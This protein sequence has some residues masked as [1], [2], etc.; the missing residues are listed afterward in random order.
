MAITPL[1]AVYDLEVSARG[2]DQTLL[3]TWINTLVISVIY[4][5]KVTN[6]SNTKLRYTIVYS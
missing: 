5:W 2:T 6:I 4:G 1:I 3:N